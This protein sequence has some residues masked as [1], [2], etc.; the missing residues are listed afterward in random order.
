MGSGGWRSGGGGDPDR[1]VRRRSLPPPRLAAA[2]AAG[3]GGKAGLALLG[4][5]DDLRLAGRGGRVS[6]RFRLRNRTSVTSVAYVFLGNC[7]LVSRKRS[8]LRASQAMGR[9]RGQESDAIQ[10][11]PADPLGR[12]TCCLRARSLRANTGSSA[13]ARRAGALRPRG[14]PQRAGEEDGQGRACGR[15]AGAPC[16]RGGGGSASRPARRSPT[17]S[18]RWRRCAH[19]SP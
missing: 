3:G 18:S 11:A 4:L 6:G 8:R 12:I 16:G 15:A 13:M 7:F 9:I 2:A 19:N 5:A 17:A 1:S 14:A 10:S